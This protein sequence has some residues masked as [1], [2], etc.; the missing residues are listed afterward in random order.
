MKIIIIDD[1]CL[2]AGALKTILEANPD[3]EVTATGSDGE[4]ACSLYREYLPDILLMDIRMKGMDGLEASRKILGEFPE[5]KILLLTTFSDDE[6]IVKALRL[7][8]KGY[9]LKQDH[10]SI[11]PALQAVYSA[12]PYSAQRSYPKSLNSCSLP[13]D[14]IM[15]PETSVNGSWISSG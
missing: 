2:V 14:L 10:T 3:I 13:T 6:Y 12:R 9:L 1:D 4:E 11:L 7:G 8:T 15:L 5:A